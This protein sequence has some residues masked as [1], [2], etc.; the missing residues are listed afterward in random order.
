MFRKLTSILKTAITLTAVIL[1][2]STVNYAHAQQ[3]TLP[4]LKDTFIPVTGVDT[5]RFPIRDRRSDR[6]SQ[7]YRNP[8]DLKDPSN[9][10]DSVIYDPKTKEYYI[11]EKV[12]S[13]YYRKP[14][15]I[16]FEEFLY[17]RSQIQERE[18]FR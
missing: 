12:G 1:A 7:I 18:Y 2:N 13:F 4:P 14:T 6:Y 8:L 16:T 10:V 17:L 11:V 9:I 15:A 5:L 3:D